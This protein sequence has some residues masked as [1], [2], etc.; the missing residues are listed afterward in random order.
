MVLFVFVLCLVSVLPV[1]LGC[2]FLMLPPRFSIT[3]IFFDFF[4]DFMLQ[5]CSFVYQDCNA[6]VILS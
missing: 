3:Y 6:S 5:Y 1:S 2:P 4:L